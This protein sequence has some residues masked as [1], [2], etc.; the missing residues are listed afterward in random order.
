MF[1]SRKIQAWG[2]PRSRI[3]ASKRTARGEWHERIGLP[4]DGTRSLTAQHHERDGQVLRGASA[5]T[6]A[7]ARES[8]P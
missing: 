6:R 4:S 5:G 8:G 1:K 3:T 7:L 2:H